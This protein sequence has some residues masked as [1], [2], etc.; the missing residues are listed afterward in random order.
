MT[1]Y[2]VRRLLHLIPLIIGITLVSFAVMQMAPGDYLDQMRQRPEVSPET[3]ARMAEQFGLDRPMWEQYARWLWGLLQG[4]LG[5]SFAWHVPVSTVIMTRLGNTLLLTITAMALSWLIAIPLGIYAALRDGSPPERALGLL[6]F[7]LLAVPEFF[8][9]FMLICLAARTGWAPTGG[10]VSA[11]HDQMGWFDRLRDIFSHLII[12]AGVL[13]AGSAASLQRFLRS[14]L[15]DV[16]HQPFIT[17][18]RARGLSAWRV[19]YRHALR[20]ALN[21]LITMFGY[22]LSGLF[23]G[24][25]LVEIVTGWPGMGSLM[26]EAVIGQDLYLVMAAM[27]M[28]AVLLVLG[29]LLADILLA[30][31]DPRVR[32]SDKA[33]G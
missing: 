33:M 15:L 10:M 17:A 29:N 8:L 7:V 26:L 27:L 6:S 30:L 1:R 21:P 14:N 13:A 20:L 16:L 32:L 22:Q 19:H 2:L 11:W 24:A 4:D 9:A 23:S 5:Y 28:G 12:P 31:A 25:A 18:L 3:V